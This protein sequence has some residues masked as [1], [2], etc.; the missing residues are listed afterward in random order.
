MR[1]LLQ[2]DRSRPAGPP[3]SVDP[4]VQLLFRELWYALRTC[5]PWLKAF[6]DLR[7]GHAF[8]STV[9]ADGGHCAHY[10]PK[11]VEAAYLNAVLTT[12]QR[13]MLQ[14]GLLGRVE[15]A[16]VSG[17]VCWTIRFGHHPDQ[18]LCGELYSFA[19]QLERERASAAIR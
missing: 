8:F 15:C 2:P 3:K 16:E 12:C 10:P 13:L 18:D 6:I 4:T 5:A 14:T 11:Y 19:E 7:R 9:T 1:M 17:E